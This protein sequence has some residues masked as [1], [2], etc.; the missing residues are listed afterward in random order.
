MIIDK[1]DKDYEEFYKVAS[2]I[3]EERATTFI[4]FLADLDS[5]TNIRLTINGQSNLSKSAQRI[6]RRRRWKSGR[7]HS[8]VRATF[9]RHPRRAI[10][11]TWLSSRTQSKASLCQI[12]CRCRTKSA[13]LATSTSIPRLSTRFTSRTTDTISILTRSSWKMACAGIMSI[14]QSVT[15]MPMQ[16]RQNV[17]TSTIVS[18]RCRAIRQGKGG[19]TV[20]LS[21]GIIRPMT[22]VTTSTTCARFWKRK[23]QSSSV[24]SKNRSNNKMAPQCG[25]FFVIRS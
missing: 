20:R 16:L 3:F 15:T 9:R 11:K 5:N 8:S 17:V 12:S 18:S 13:I 14:W 24:A 6:L 19:H 1:L 23:S 25:A 22:K 7:G 21:D 4:K 2:T 10:R